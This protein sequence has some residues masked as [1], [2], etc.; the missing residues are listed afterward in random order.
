M[1]EHEEQDEVTKP[2]EVWTPLLRLLLRSLTP[3]EAVEDG[4]VDERIDRS[5]QRLPKWVVICFKGWN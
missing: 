3:D 5:Y 4:W 2:M 1:D